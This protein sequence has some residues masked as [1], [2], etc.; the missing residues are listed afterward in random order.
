MPME[1]GAAAAAPALLIAQG[2][3]QQRS[4]TETRARERGRVEARKENRSSTHTLSLSVSHTQ[5]AA[6]HTHTHTHTHNA[7]QESSAGNARQRVDKLHPTDQLH[8]HRLDPSG[9]LHQ[10][11]LS[12]TLVYMLY[13]GRGAPRAPVGSQLRPPPL[14]LAHCG[15]RPAGTWMPYLMR[16]LTKMR[17]AF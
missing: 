7:K 2:E 10:S 16:R 8:P 4:E 1:A 11:S 6:R 3:G 14:Q 12:Y 15:P 13:K 9:Q 5:R 17:C